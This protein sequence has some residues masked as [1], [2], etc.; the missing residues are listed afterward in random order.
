MVFGMSSLF[1]LQAI[2]ATA[3]P[4]KTI[5]YNF[6][7][8]CIYS[9]RAMFE[10]GGVNE[11]AHV[12]Y[13]QVLVKIGSDAAVYMA[14]D[15]FHVVN[16]TYSQYKTLINSFNIVDSDPTPVPM[17][18]N[19]FIE[20][21]KAAN[22]GKNFTFSFDT[23][24]IRESRIRFNAANPNSLFTVLYD[25]ILV[26]NTSDNTTNYYNL[27]NDHIVR[28]VYQDY[29]TLINN[30]TNVNVNEMQK[31]EYARLYD[32][33]NSLTQQANNPLNIL[34]K[35]NLLNQANAAKAQADAIA[36][37][38]QTNTGMLLSTITGILNG[39]IQ[40]VVNVLKLLGL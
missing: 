35:Q 30:F 38:I 22:P 32:L 2:V 7:N 27:I 3:N 15:P 20:K 24:C 21:L 11:F 6:D 12:T 26:N 40:T 25:K 19:D 8:S 34:N 5:T 37:Q 39:T 10:N 28:M 36:A 14:L 18:Y 23:K 31:S 4:G 33:F 13:N 17:D 16:M 1:E 29:K 9:M